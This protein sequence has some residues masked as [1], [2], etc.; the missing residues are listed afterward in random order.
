VLE[1]S[2]EMGNQWAKIQAAVGASSNVF[3]LIRRVP[4]IRDSTSV[5]NTLLELQA[6]QEL[7]AASKCRT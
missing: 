2:N 6:V 3:D 7:I 1:L 5:A 4:A